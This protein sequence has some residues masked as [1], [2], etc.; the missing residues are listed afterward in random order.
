[1]SFTIPHNCT[2]HTNPHSLSLRAQNLEKHSRIGSTLYGTTI[3][4]SAWSS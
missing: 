3:I 1:L 4:N 2:F